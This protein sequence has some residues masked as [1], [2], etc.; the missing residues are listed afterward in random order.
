MSQGI[1]IQIYWMHFLGAGLL[2]LLAGMVLIILAKRG[3]RQGDNPFCAH[4]QYDLNGI[5]ESAGSCPECGRDISNPRAVV[6]GRRQLR[7]GMLIIGSAIAFVAINWMSLVG[8]RAYHMVS[9]IQYK[10]MTWLL[11]AAVGEYNGT[12]H[13]NTLELIRR[14]DDSVLSLEQ[15][16]EL[17][18]EVLKL[19]AANSK[20]NDRDWR[21][22]LQ[23]LLMRQCFSQAQVDQLLKQN[24]SVTFQTR[25]VLRRDRHW[26]YDIHNNFSDLHTGWNGQNRIRIRVGPVQERLLLNGMDYYPVRKTDAQEMLVSDINSSHST[27]TSLY[28]KVLSKVPDG[29]GRFEVVQNLTLQLIEPFEYEP[30]TFEASTGQDVIIVGKDAIIDTFTTTPQHQQEMAKAW[31]GTRVVTGEKGAQVWVRVD[32]PPIAMAMSVWVIDGDQAHRIGDVYVPQFA[33]DKWYR[34]KRNKTM[35]W[36]DQVTVQLRPDQAASDNKLFL[37]TYW[38]SM[39]Q[40]QDVPLNVPYMPAFIMDITLNQTV[41]QNVTLTHLK[42]ENASTISFYAAVSKCPVRVNYQVQGPWKLLTDNAFDV[43]PPSNSSYQFMVEPEPELKVMTIHYQPNTEWE[44][45]GYLDIL[46]YGMPIVFNS[47][48]VPLG[49][50]LVKEKFFGKVVLPKIPEK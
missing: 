1:S 27:F 4:C 32:S 9:W 43:R 26:Y 49:D 41:E 28:G 48:P 33:S 5:V 7:L 16:K 10:P 15:A 21:Q 39:M 29:P 24:Y 13:T 40:Q 2:F 14:I 47:I 18:P 11:P 25:P 19:H 37:D 17:V 35:N 22:V 46:P 23:S 20:W 31:C 42:R 12:K 8:Y 34:L 6:R 38:G 50:E 36:S 3:K 44:S 30:V 45:S